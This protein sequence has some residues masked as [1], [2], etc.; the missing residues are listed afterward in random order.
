MPGPGQSLVLV[1]SP[2]Q[3]SLLEHPSISAGVG[4]TAAGVPVS[5]PAIPFFFPAW[6]YQRVPDF[7]VHFP[8]ISLKG[9]V[10]CLKWSD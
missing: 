3:H 7:L 6:L 2:G 8:L 9:V 10:L 4:S 5:S 1:W